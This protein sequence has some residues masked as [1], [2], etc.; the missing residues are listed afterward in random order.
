MCHM[1]LPS[2]LTCCVWGFFFVSFFWGVFFFGQLCFLVHLHWCPSQ[3]AQM[4][5]IILFNEKRSVSAADSLLLPVEQMHVHS[6]FLSSL[7]CLHNISSWCCLL[8]AGKTQENLSVCA[9]PVIK[10]PISADGSAGT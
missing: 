1:M 10:Q 6:L 9:I 4:L 3:C 2:L 8:D 7:H 5:Q